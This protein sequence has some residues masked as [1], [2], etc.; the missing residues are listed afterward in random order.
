MAISFAKTTLQ[1][2][3]VCTLVVHILVEG[4]V[5]LNLCRGR[6]LCACI[7]SKVT[8]VKFE[9]FWP[10]SNGKNCSSQLVSIAFCF[11]LTHS[12]VDEHCGMA[13]L[14]ISNEVVTFQGLKS[15]FWEHEVM[16]HHI[17]ISLNNKPRLSF[18]KLARLSTAY[19]HRSDSAGAVVCWLKGFWRSHSAK[20]PTWYDK[21]TSH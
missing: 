11:E 10:P 16:C 17:G 6:P 15:P 2:H 12:Y 8:L 4:T 9:S 19:I 5:M 1:R 20:M 13:A 18:Y 3:T 7:D 14:P 21:G